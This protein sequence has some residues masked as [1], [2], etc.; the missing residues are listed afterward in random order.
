M[1]L[2]QKLFKERGKGVSKEE[3]GVMGKATGKGY[4]SFIDKNTGKF[5][6]TDPTYQAGEMQYIDPLANTLP[7]S[8]AT[9]PA[10]Q[11]MRSYQTGVGAVSDREMEA[12][13]RAELA[14][15]GFNFET[16]RGAMSNNE[17]Q[18]F[19]IASQ[20]VPDEYLSGW[21]TQRAP[22]LR[23][24]GVGNIDLQVPPRELRNQINA[25]TVR[26]L[27]AVAG[28][29]YDFMEDGQSVG[30]NFT[31]DGVS[32]RALANLRSREGIQANLGGGMDR[33]AVSNVDTMF[34]QAL[35]GLSPREQAEIIQTTQGY[36]DEQVDNFKR[37][38]L[39]G[40]VSSYELERPYLQ[41]NLGFQ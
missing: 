3:Q 29:D 18:N 27:G 2:L 37:Q 25:M 11:K 26:P 15:R 39:Q 14:S 16:D 7:Y 5:N 31:G 6:R 8:N 33:G 41:S 38:Y 13:K 28:R 24:M 9:K 34:A 21:L 4:E 40:R 35:S 22:A 10:L 17:L 23:Q 20:Y 19:K 32:E 30:Y 12:S 1:E 36:N